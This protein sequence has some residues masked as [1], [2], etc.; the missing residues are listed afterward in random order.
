MINEELEGRQMRMVVNGNGLNLK[1][2][3]V[4]ILGKLI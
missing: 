1:S 4:V 3:A 2:S